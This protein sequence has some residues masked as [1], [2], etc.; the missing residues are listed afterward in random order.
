MPLPDLNIFCIRVAPGNRLCITFPG[1]TEICSIFAD[2]K[3][4][5]G[6]EL[7]NQLLAHVN[8][9]LAPLTPIFN[10]IDVLVAIVNCVKAVEDALGSVPPDP[11]KIAQ[12]FPQLSRAL[13]RL[14]RLIPQLTIPALIGGLLDLLI[15]NLIGLRTQLLAV[16]NKQLRVLAAQTRAS[17]LGSVQLLTATNCAQEEIDA[18]LKNWNENAKP[19]GRLINT[20]NA[21]L[22]LA[23]LDPLPSIQDLGADAEK[24]LAPID[25]MIQ[26]FEAVRRGFP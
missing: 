2:A 18:T 23:G 3:I 4:P 5:A 10:I 20:A 11:T 13:A 19:L 9:A 1:G 26:A 16:I 25:S 21:L 24:A 14:L 15:A 12:C 6:D 22:Q 7:T 8:T 17:K